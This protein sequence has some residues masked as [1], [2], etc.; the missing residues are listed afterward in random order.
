MDTLY[1]DEA[2]A[3]VFDLIKDS[4]VAMMATADEGGRLFHA[5]P[6]VAPRLDKQEDFDGALYFF[7]GAT[8]PKVDEIRANPHV[9]LTYANPDKQSYVSL[10][11]QATVERDRS[12]IDQLWTKEIAAWFPDGKDDPNLILVRFDAEEAEYWDAPNR[13]VLGAAYLKS[14]IGGDRPHFEGSAGKADLAH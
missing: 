7:T 11:G 3:K 10:S 8:S 4:Q 2:R 14:L 13:F 12:K 9:L 1:G 6:M 5:R